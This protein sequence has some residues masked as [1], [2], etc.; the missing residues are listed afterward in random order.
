MNHSA[1]SASRC[2]SCHNGSFTGEGTKGAHGHG[3]VPGPRRDQR[4]DC[5]SC[6]ASAA[7]GFASWAGGTLR[8]RG[9]RHQLLELPQRHHRDRPED[10]A[11]HPGA[12]VQCSNC[13]S[14][15][16]ASFTTYT[17]NHTAVSASRC[18][19]CHNGSF[20]S[21]GKKG[22]E[23]KSRDHPSTTA[24]CG[25]CHTST[26]SFD[27]RRR[28]P[29][30]CSTTATAAPVAAP[31]AAATATTTTTATP[32]AAPR[33]AA[34]QP[35]TATASTAAPTTTT[36]APGA[37]TAVAPAAAAR[38]ATATTPTAA[39]AITANPN[40]AIANAPAATSP[41]VTSPNAA[42][43]S[44]ASPNVAAS[45]PAAPPALGTPVVP[46]TPGSPRVGGRFSHAGLTS[47]CAACHNGVAAPGKPSNHVVTNAPCENCH[48][49]TV[50]FAGA[51]M[52]HSRNH[53]E[54]RQLPQRQ[55]RS[56]EVRRSISSRT[57][58]AR[59]ATRARRHLPV[60]G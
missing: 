36:A 42:A 4:P 51:R 55:N 9:D 11:A 20:T 21:Q 57:I 56:R 25:C 43:M 31:A 54:L 7:A 26:T 58:R 48:K 8:P 60:L 59:P 13:H 16:A 41:V 45:S 46:V 22:P 10:A 53:C 1:V 3:L 37:A 33:T 27:P 2:D 49:S 30:G 52:N 34:K 19:S 14:N 18:D 6:H 35:A 32:T 15:T 50:T 47:R 28:S 24:D 17:M 39:T 38:P 23:G 40:A 5:V 44:S 29:A 12:G